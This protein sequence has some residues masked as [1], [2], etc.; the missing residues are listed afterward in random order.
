MTISPE[1]Q[2]GLA[3]LFA[4]QASSSGPRSAIEDET[5]V[6]TYTELH[7]KAISLACQIRNLNPADTSPVGILIPRSLSHVLSQVALVY[8]GRA[9]VPLNEKLPDSHLERMLANLGTTLV[10]TDAAHQ[11]RLASWQH[12]VVDH[13]DISADGHEE[14]EISQVGPDNCSHVL[15]TSGT[16]GQ[17]KAVETVAQGIINLSFDPIDLVKPGQRVGHGTSVI[18]DTSLVEIWVSLLRGATI[19]VIPMAT[20]LDAAALSVFIR[21]K[22]L[23]VLQLTTSLLSVTAFACPGAFLTLDTLLTGGEAINCQSINSIF[24]AGAP[25]RIINGYGPTEASVYTLMHEVSREEARNNQIPVGKPLGNVEVFV[26]GEDFLPVKPGDVGELLICGV[27]VAR[28][29]IGERMKTAKSFLHLPHLPQKLTQGPSRAY[30]TGDLMRANDQG[31]H[32]YIGRI[33]NQVKIRGQRVELEALEATLLQTNLVNAAVVI[34]ITPKE[35]DR[36]QFLLAY[37][38]PAAPDVTPAAIL[39]SYLDIAPHLMVLRVKLIDS[40]PLMATGKA[41]RK[42]LEK[43]HDEELAQSRIKAAESQVGSR[44]VAAELEYIWIDVLGLPVERLAPTDDFLE[45]GGSSLMA[46]TMIARINQTFDIGVRSQMLYENTTLEK[47][48]QMVTNVRNGSD[49]TETLAAQEIWWND[50]QLGRSLRPKEMPIPHWQDSSE[51][52]VF[53]TGATGF[54]GALLLATLAARSNV[55]QVACLVRAADKNSATRRIQETLDKYQLRADLE[56]VIV[57][58]GSFALPKLG[59]SEDDYDFYAEW[60]SVVFHLGAKV[61]YVAPYSSHRQDNVIGTMNMLD[62]ANHKRLKALHYSSTIA[63]YGPTGYVTGAKLLPEDERPAA[64][65]AA[66]PYDTGYA[67]SQYVAEGIIWAAI[68]NGFPVAVYRPGFVLGHSKMGICN[69]NDFASRLFT[70]CMEMGTYP[71]LPD[72]RKEFVPVDFVVN[73]ILHISSSHTNL[74]Q[75]YNLVQPDLKNAIDINTSFDL[76]NRMIPA[77]L[78]GIPYEEWVN[79]LSMRLN[80]PL[81]PLTPM[82]KEKVLADKSRWEVYEN[83][84]EYGRVNIRR[85]L[86]DAPHILHPGSIQDLFLQSLSSWIP[87][88]K[89]PIVKTAEIHVHEKEAIQV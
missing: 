7:S 51:G 6:I 9:C 73:A 70:S 29:Y 8:A 66:L 42:Q 87:D 79:S 16:T 62:F 3:V 15:H 65:L 74:G 4:R 37:C 78:R 40:L 76:L 89:E 31:I 86:Q 49:Q 13:R 85:A 17:P 71:I 39:K 58:P 12:L 55:K 32:Q 30:R 20:V 26:V 34:K 14:F 22:R 81:H 69:G 84:A 19:V 61:S 38:I 18:F 21:T 35:V 80:D 23:D 10:I 1:P 52:R 46:A 5:D 88:R 41:D 60:S 54:V 33:D 2:P 77:P 25:G 83:M 47:F 11:H 36:A 50:S 27:G 28:G 59:L 75:A 82:L 24:D 56:K 68:D 72:Q 67:Q 64:H 63:A 43:L 53:V 44:D 45:M 57:L 48:T